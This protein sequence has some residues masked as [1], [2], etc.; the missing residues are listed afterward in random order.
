MTGGPLERGRAMAA[1]VLPERAEPLREAPA[2]VVA[3]PST[4]APARGRRALTRPLVRLLDSLGDRSVANLISIWFWMIAIFGVVY[5]LAGVV[6][7]HGLR[8]GQEPIASNLAGLLTAVYFS[9]VTA[10]SIGYGDVVPVGWF[11]LLAIAEGASGLLLFGVVIS[12][13][14]SRH[15]EELTAEIHRIT[16]EDRLGRV[17]TNLHFVHSEL[18]AIAAMCANPEVRPSETMIRSESAASVFLG[19]MRT[20]HDLLYRPQQIPEEEVLE[21][22]LASVASGCRELG[23]LLT[24]LPV[25]YPRSHAMT[26]TLHAMAVLANDI[27]GECVPRVYAADLRYWMDEIQREARRLV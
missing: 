10:L 1:P 20:V 7:G 19:E 16:F 11:R 23:D 4:V 27:C 2:A 18:Q 14:V 15:Q 3:R 9:F 26:A 5:W 24:C 8:A 25:N 6:C 17:R 12:K 22:I 13:L 21:S